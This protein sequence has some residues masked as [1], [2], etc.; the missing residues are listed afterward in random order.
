MTEG[1]DT[2]WR[3]E[4]TRAARRLS[5]G[6]WAGILCGVV[7]GGIGGRLAMFLLRVTSNPRLSGRLTD[8]GFR[9]GSFTTSTL[10]LVFFCAVAGMLGGLFYL[11]VRG[12]LP[13]RIRPFAIATFGGAFGG[14]IVIHPGRLDF[15]QL[16][17]LA[18]AVAMFIALPALYG[19]ALSWLAERLLDG[20][21]GARASTSVIA[22]LPLVGIGLAGPVGLLLLAAIGGGW[23]AN[24]Q[25][26]PLTRAWHSTPGTWLGRGALAGITILALVALVHDITA[27]L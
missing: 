10:F 17:P 6:M 1:K 26:I 23:L 3:G 16:D 11:L 22:F 14:A 25:G 12:W 7:V 24:R 21:D 15:T 20:T 2:T 8:D 18:L 4:A 27:V 13:D 19:L 9:I 5:R